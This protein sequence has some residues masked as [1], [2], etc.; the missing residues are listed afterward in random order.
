[1]LLLIGTKKG[2]FIA[3]SDGERRDWALRGPFCETWPINHLVGDPTS[4]AIYGTG[5][6]EWF[7]PAVW[8]SEDLGES[9]S[10]SSEGLAY[11]EGEEPIK[12][13]WSL[14]AAGET[15][16]AGVE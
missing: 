9:W 3:Q 2:A 1:M 11:P 7:G 16:Y 13:G 12:S 15:L 14:A 6:N 8:K 5:G 10:H 4:G